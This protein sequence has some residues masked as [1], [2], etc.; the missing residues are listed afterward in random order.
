M[1]L[2]DEK[3]GSETDSDLSS[4]SMH[5][6]DKIGMIKK[7]DSQIVLWVWV[8]ACYALQIFFSL[9]S[10]QNYYS[11]RLIHDQTI[12]IIRDHFIF[13]KQQKKQQLK[14]NALHGESMTLRLAMNNVMLACIIHNWSANWLFF[15]LA[16]K[17][18][19]QVFP[20]A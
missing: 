7:Q 19:K 3:T 9:S 10:S 6:N 1:W 14:L 4:Q 8:I 15:S 5:D 12:K 13:L 20:F 17:K 11:F 2:H 16:E 18:T